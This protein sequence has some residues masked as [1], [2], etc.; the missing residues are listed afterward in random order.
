MTN[1][2]RL[3]YIM[4]YANYM[5]NL[6]TYDQTK[7][8]VKGLESVIPKDILGM[9][10]PNEIQL[11]ITGGINDIDINDLQKHTKLNRFKP[12]EK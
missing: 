12:E 10:F 6:R 8:F 5:L 7:H 2:N 3:Q 1:D 11:L 9:F 4:Y